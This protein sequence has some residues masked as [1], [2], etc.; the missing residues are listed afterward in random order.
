MPMTSASEAYMDM[1]RIADAALQLPNGVAEVHPNKSSAH[2]QKFRFY[3]MRMLDRQENLRAEGTLT[4]PY[5]ILGCKVYQKQD[6]WYL[7]IRRPD[8]EVELKSRMFIDP[9]TGKEIK[10]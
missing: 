7:H 9:E 3:Q 5:D 10:I 1:R 4:S 8:T 2:H 6:K